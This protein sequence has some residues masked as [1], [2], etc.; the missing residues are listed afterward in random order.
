MTRLVFALALA[1]LP[2]A[3]QT[4]SL[5]GIIT[6]AQGSAVPSAVVTATNTNTSASRKA[7]T[8]STGAYSLVQVPPGNYKVIVE[9]PGFRMQ[10]ADITLQTNTPATWNVKLEVGQVTETV[11]VTGEAAVVN[12]ETAAVG[13]PFNETQIKQL[14][15]QT[16][17]I[18]SLLSLEPGV[19]PTGQV[20]GAKSDQ[21]NVTLDGVDVNNSWGGTNANGFNAAL[22]IPLDSV[23]EFRTTVA[24]VGANQGH[25]S[26]GQVSIVTKGGS[27]QF[28]GSGYEYN[29]N[30]LTSANT[31]TNNRAV[32]FVPRAA[33]VR[34]QYGASLGGPVLKN[35][36]FF[37]YNYEGRTDRS[38]S[39]VKDTVPSETFKQGNI[40]VLL[41]S[42][43][44]VTLTPAMIK[45]I[46]PLGIGANPY[47]TN[48]VKQYPAGNNPSGV[49][50]KGLNFNQLI[51][52]T[53]QKLDNHV[54]VGRMDFNID[55]AGK[56]TLMLRGTLNGA[57][58]DGTLAQFPG[59]Q[60][61]SRNLDNARGLAA[62]YTAVISPTLVNALSYGYTRPSSAST[63][64]STPPVPSFGFTAFTATPRASRNVSPA[65]NINDDLTWTRGRHSIQFGVALKFGEDDNT[66][67]SNF[68]SFSFSRNTL[69]NL[70]ADISNPTQAYIQANLVPGGVLA[71]T[72]NVQNAFGA[73]FGILN[74]WGATY[75]F[76]IDGKPI[77]FGTSYGSAFISKEYEGYAQD[78]FKWKRNFTVTY[79]LRYS[80]FG[81]PY[82]KNGVQVVPQTPLSNFF[83]DR[84]YAQANG[85][86]GSALPDALISYKIGGPVNHGQ[87]YYPLDKKLFAPRLSIAWSPADGTLE[88]KIL[89]KGSAVRLG[90]SVVY[91][92]YGAALAEAFA[93]GGSPG[94][95]S[96]VA[97]PVNT[98]FTT[99]PRFDGVTLPQFVAPLGGQFPYTPPAIVG[100]FTN[101][102]GIQSD[103]KAPYNY[104]LNASY[105]RPLPKRLSIELG[106]VGRLSH[107]G[108]LKQDFGQPLLNFKDPKS[109]QTFGQAGAALAAVY[110]GMIGSGMSLAQAAAAVKA[111][112]SLV[113]TQPFLENMFPG[114]KAATNLIGSNASASANFFYD[115][116]SGFAGSFT[117]TVNDMDRTRQTAANGGCYSAFGCNTFF[118]MQN[119]SLQAYSNTGSA[120]YHAATIVLRRAVSHGWGFD[121]NYTFAHAL[122]NG[123]G[124]ESS[125]GSLLQDAFN[126]AAFRGPSDFDAK[127]AVSIDYVIELPVGQGK[128]L[129]N[130]MPKALDYALGGWQL[131][132]L[133]TFRSG[134]PLTFLVSGVY[135]T[136]YQSSSYAILAPGAKLPTNGLT[137]DQTGYP[138]LFAND[139]AAASA[140]VASNPGTVGTR[141]II[142]G[143]NSFNVD[144]SISKYFK[145]PKEGHRIQLRAEAFNLENRVNFGNPSSTG[146]PTGLSVA[147]PTTFG[148]VTAPNSARVMQ[149]AARYEF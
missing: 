44:T 87:D 70:G 89:G 69:A 62:R 84:V 103:L 12:T 40:L 71:S 31:W 111:N 135:N 28:H 5:Q 106:Y 120:A 121:F 129:W 4:S 30:T 137:V 112:P 36:L 127:H 42:G 131:A 56:H 100:G 49:T 16:R 47:I 45:A 146:T 29:R 123:S 52:N 139:S 122:D 2:L 9:K 82:E 91:D 116:Y 93:S 125:G 34:N 119:A 68:P 113:P 26:G 118:S 105:A 43:Q 142:R 11:S 149:F 13:N 14:P 51:F 32:P 128:A 108:L 115:W 73:M 61:T 97:Q 148:E 76:G 77:P 75:R 66:S 104:A 143:L 41:K 95:A 147:S 98:N 17:N 132:G 48:L 144:L 24:G 1:A 18:V 81:V 83:A 19:A 126:P 63:G 22:P 8:D 114:I 60:A 65:S 37:F 141:G 86:P 33:L 107:R 109:G 134:T 96:S 10:S 124:S 79:G 117:D 21:N 64:V 20:G 140:F 3:A 23:Q 92:H 58:Q 130:S 46:D 7:L 94:L 6:D 85:I 110:N 101:S 88:E 59:Q 145:L 53:P 55:P 39:T 72:T 136:N 25:S 67:G 35:R 27:N 99:S 38:A 80:L 50:D 90:A 57:G 138:S 74:N 133:T 78:S 54:Q 15:L 102:T